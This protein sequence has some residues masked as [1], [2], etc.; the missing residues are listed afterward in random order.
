[1]GK[2]VTDRACPDPQCAMFG[3]IG[4]GNVA[5]RGFLR[6]KRGRRRRCRCEACGATFVPS[7]GAPYHRLKCTKAQ[8]DK[9]AALSV[10]GTVE[11]GHRTHMHLSWNT[12]A[13]RL[14]RAAEAAERFGARLLTGYMLTELQ[15]DEI[16]MFIDSKRRVRSRP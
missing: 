2:P 16:R 11:V 3:K 4:K 15:A 8:F 14:E 6:L 9:D 12:V 1:M 7:V 5:F 10:G 13:R